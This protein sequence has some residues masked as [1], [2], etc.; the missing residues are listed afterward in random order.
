MRQGMLYSYQ[1]CDGGQEIGAGE[2]VGPE[3]LGEIIRLSRLRQDPEIQVS[4]NLH[5]LF[6]T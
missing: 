2:E 5:S 3:A 1:S 6:T 4:S